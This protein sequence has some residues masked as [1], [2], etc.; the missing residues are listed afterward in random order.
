MDSTIPIATDTSIIK[1][2]RKQNMMYVKIKIKKPDGRLLLGFSTAPETAEQLREKP[3]RRD[4]RV[5][6]HGGHGPGEDEG[7]MVRRDHLFFLLFVFF[8]CGKSYSRPFGN[9][10]FISSRLLKQILA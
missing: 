8:K 10:F 5:C 4:H 1:T 6:H 3:R 2:L 7:E 9:H